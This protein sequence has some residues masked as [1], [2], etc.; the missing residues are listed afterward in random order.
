MAEKHHSDRLAP[1]VRL[2]RLLAPLLLFAVCAGFYW[3]MLFT[4]RQTWLD[5]PDIAYQ[6]VPWF[7]FQ[8]AEWH[9]GRF[10][11]WDPYLWGG[12]SLIGQAQPGAAYPLNWLLV[13]APLKDGKIRVGALHWYFVWIHFLAALFCYWLCVDLGRSRGASF[14]AGCAFG[15]GGYVGY[16]LWPQMLN[17]AIWAPL[18]FLFL[19][20]SA[21]GRRPISSAALSGMFL[22]VAWLSGHHQIPIYA[23]LAAAGVWVYLVA[24]QPRRFRL[25]ALSAVF[26]AL[27][28]ALQTLPAWEY[29]RLAKRWVGL[30]DPVGWGDRISYSIHSQ[31]SLGPT[32]LLGFVMPGAGRHSDVYLSVVILALAV[33]GVVR[34]WSFRPVRI[35]TIM[36]AGSLLFA[37]GG[38]SVVHGILYAI[39]P[40]V[41][42]ARNP[43]AS[44]VM[45]HLSIASLSTYGIDSF[46]SRKARKAIVVLGVAILVSLELHGVAAAVF[47]NRN[48]YFREYAEY[49]E[50]LDVIGKANPG[51]IVVN[52]REIP[53]NLG[54][55]HGI[56]VFGGY[57]ASLPANLLRMDLGSPRVRDL[58]GVTHSV[59]RTG[60]N[61]SVTGSGGALPR[62]WAVHEAEVV[63][64]LE[65]LAR[66]VSGGEFDFRRKTLLPGSAPSLERCE[67]SDAIRLAVRSSDRVVIEAAMACRGMVIVSDNHFPGWIATVDGNPRPIHEAYGIFRGVVVDAGKH[68]VT[69]VYRP[70][71]VFAGAAL[72]AAG[73]FGVLM[74]VLL[75]RRR[76]VWNHR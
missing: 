65:K 49:T 44:I 25:A 29:G 67:A 3:Q 58:F 60:A 42:K 74:L 15:L 8:A 70:W 59:S 64:D 55:W 13:L 47:E 1:H 68:R 32:S 4:D 14:I 36:A 72:T 21:N 20:R 28:S 11:L 50:L 52:S 69:M 12:Q 30:E 10:P 73:V 45:Y 17:G 75:D 71:T 18:V 9:S 31:F 41:E 61:W 27:T 62:A 16:T 54:D 34:N 40:L 26:L 51:R 23:T 7:Q 57:V 37:L 2:R 53:F 43:S 19:L 48:K 46:L 33:L 56:D 35:F 38:N 76:G 66:V 24:E 22:G 5:N 39:V 63:S 6:V